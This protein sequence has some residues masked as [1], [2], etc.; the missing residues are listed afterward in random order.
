[1]GG[2]R[3]LIE[4]STICIGNSDINGVMVI[5]REMR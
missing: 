2:F 1:M 5:N 4:Y 3:S